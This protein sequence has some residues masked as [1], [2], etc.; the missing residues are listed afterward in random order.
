MRSGF[1]VD[2]SKLLKKS[3]IG[4]GYET[5][6]FSYVLEHTYTPDFI[7]TNKKGEKIYIEAKGYFRPRDRKLLLA[8]K[9][10]HP[11]LDLRLWFMQDNFLSNK[12]K[13]TRYSKWAEKNGFKYHVGTTIPK[14]WFR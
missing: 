9:K 14:S 2:I 5:E 1:E 13:A 8:I 6:S 12:T 11:D 3:G 7:I 10:Q 4:F